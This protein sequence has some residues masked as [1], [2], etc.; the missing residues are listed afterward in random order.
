MLYFLDIGRIAS[1][2]IGINGESKVR[3]SLL[4]VILEMFTPITDIIG[5]LPQCLLCDS[6]HLSLLNASKS[7]TRLI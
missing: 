1:E 2:N 6:I 7:K 5:T 4:M 3:F